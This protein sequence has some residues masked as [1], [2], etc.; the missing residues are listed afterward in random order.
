MCKL[1]EDEVSQT[2]SAVGLAM[3]M[4]LLLLFP[5]ASGLPRLLFLPFG[6]EH[7]DQ[8]IQYNQSVLISQFPAL[9]VS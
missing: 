8:V 3:L 7:G 9:Y 1:A 5:L 4:L 6:E 2:R